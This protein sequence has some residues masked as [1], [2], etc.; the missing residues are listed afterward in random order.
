M[1]AFVVTGPGEACVREV[2][3]PVPG[4]GEVVVDV[5][6]VGVCGTDVEFFTGDMAYL[7]SGHA[8]YP[9]RL[10]HEWCGTVGA[11][12]DGVDPAWVGRRTT[13]D[14]MLGCGRCERCTTGRHHVCDARYEIGI[15]GGFP[16]ALAERMAIPVVALHPLPGT[17]DDVAGA[18]V[19]PG[20]N[21]LRAV[22]A[23]DV[24][25][26]ERLLVLGPGTIGLLVALIARAAGVEVHLV[27][28]SQR[29]R[30]FAA[31]L[32][33]TGVC[34]VDTIPEV[35]FHGVVDATDAP[36][37]PPLAARLVEPARTV[38]YVGLSTTPSLVDTRDL[39]LKDVTAVG[40]LSGSPG[41]DGTIE[42]YA[43]GAVDPRPL[44]AATVGLEDVAD[45]LAG[46]RPAGAGPGPKFHVD[47][48]R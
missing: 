25:P 42:R 35:P 2:P 1:R 7:R 48:R 33:F 5:E 29:S 10:G 38:V 45:V 41:L 8:A 21:A 36:A 14:T 22:L 3:E 37:M 9:M 44:V 6:R 19:E 13:G 4:P 17:V 16:G 28:R 27:G 18:L 15:R 34:T 31:S 43:S 30:D 39:L 23:A 40:I 12:G 26:G 11:V 32:G 24:R 20:A 46:R 47:P